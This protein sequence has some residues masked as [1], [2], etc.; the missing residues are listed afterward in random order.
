[1][2]PLS[3]SKRRSE[4]LARLIAASLMLSVPLA[5]F[6][7]YHAHPIVGVLLERG[8]FDREAVS[9]AAQM[10]TFQALGI[11]ISVCNLMLFRMLQI[12]NKL[13]FA[14]FLMLASSLAGLCSARS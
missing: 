9:L 14:G 13:R 3:E 10:L 6:L 4:R 11:P 5:I 8:R 12:M 7:C 1:M 2:V